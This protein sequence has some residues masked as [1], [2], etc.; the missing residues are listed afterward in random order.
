MILFRTHQ[1]S[2]SVLLLH[3]LLQL[4]ETFLHTLVK[5]PQVIRHPLPVERDASSE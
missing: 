2:H 1:L 5:R 3:F 4:F